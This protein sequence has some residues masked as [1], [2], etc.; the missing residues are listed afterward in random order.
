MVLTLTENKKGSNES[1]LEHRSKRE[2]K[3]RD[4]KESTGVARG[5]R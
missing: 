5:P 2:R 4:G 1:A 3:K